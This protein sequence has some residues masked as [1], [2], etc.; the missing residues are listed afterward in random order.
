MTPPTFPSS[1]LARNEIFWSSAQPEFSRESPHIPLCGSNPS[2]LSLLR[3]CFPVRSSWSC[4]LSCMTSITSFS[5]STTSAA[6]ATARRKTWWRRRVNC[7]C[8]KS[9]CYLETA[10][11][12]P[13]LQK[14]KKEK[15]KKILSTNQNSAVFLTI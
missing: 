2:H 12:P 9:F 4:R 7:S 11:C 10:T 5:P 15:R 8:L 13:P 14:R 1:Q 6:T 3:L